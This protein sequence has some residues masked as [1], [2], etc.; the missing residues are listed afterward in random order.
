M[1][2]TPVVIILETIAVCV[3][4]A[5]LVYGGISNKKDLTAAEDR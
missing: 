2:A 1:G 3:A 4:L 5:A